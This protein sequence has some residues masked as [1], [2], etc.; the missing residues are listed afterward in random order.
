[1][2]H[3]GICDGEAETC[4]R[5]SH[6]IHCCLRH[7]KRAALCAV[8]VFS[9]VTDLLEHLQT[10][11]LDLLFL[12]TYLSPR[13][14]DRG[15]GLEV[16]RQIN[17]IDPFCKIALISQTT[18]FAPSS[19]DIGAFYYLLKPW[20]KDK[21]A[22]VLDRAFC[23]LK[24]DDPPFSVKTSCG[25]RR[26]PHSDI[27]FIENIDHHQ[28]LHLKNGESLRM[29]SR[30]ADLFCSLCENP[31]FLMP[32]RAY[33]VN[34]FHVRSFQSRSFILTDGSVVPISKNNYKRVMQHYL[35]VF[36]HTSV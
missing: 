7:S 30:L 36:P 14:G 8:I 9:D 1:M 17:L 2:I 28:L 3:I 10:H 23:A 6:D 26:V 16:A 33:I 12:G 32:H 24:R 11:G 22:Q 29:S 4:A 34:L 25:F 15:E 35:D 31:Y 27:V 21:I 19:Y 20:Q 5:L 13:E 18:A